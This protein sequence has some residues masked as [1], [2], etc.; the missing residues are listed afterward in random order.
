L[1]FIWVIHFQKA[2]QP[3]IG[4]EYEPQ[5]PTTNSPA[6][7]LLKSFWNTTVLQH[8]QSEV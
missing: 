3:T 4:Q 1:K 8:P 7:L 5:D 2:L 6:A